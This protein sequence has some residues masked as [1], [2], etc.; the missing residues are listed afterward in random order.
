MHKVRVELEERSYDI[1]IGA[2]ALSELPKND[3][4]RTLLVVDSTVKALH[5]ARIL[6]ALG[7]KP[8][9]VFVFPAGEASKKPETAVEICR[10]AARLKFDRKCRF[11]AAGGGVTGDLA[12]F[13][14]AIY[15]RGIEFILKVKP[16]MAT[17]AFLTG[18]SAFIRSLTRLSAT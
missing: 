7:G 11:A 8:E 3:G 4:K 6:S 5:G 18:M 9:E 2:G 15:M 17:R 1:T 14:A 13:A 12:G 10:F 16:S